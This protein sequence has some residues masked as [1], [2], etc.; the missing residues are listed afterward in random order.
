VLNTVLQFERVYTIS[1]VDADSKEEQIEQ[2]E[3]P[4][5]D[6]RRNECVTIEPNWDHNA[7]MRPALT[8]DE[9]DTEV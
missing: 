1:C 8:K 3:D 2:K 4:I 9:A 6:V 5:E 7:R